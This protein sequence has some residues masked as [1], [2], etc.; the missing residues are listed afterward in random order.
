MVIFQF[1]MLVFVILSDTPQKL[2]GEFRVTLWSFPPMLTEEVKPQLPKV[3][4]VEVAKC[5]LLVVGWWWWW[6]SFSLKDS[7]IAF[8]LGN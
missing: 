8:P 2:R 1:V 6:S 5:S 4:Y 7:T 3:L